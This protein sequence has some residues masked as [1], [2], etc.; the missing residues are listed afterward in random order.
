MEDCHLKN[1]ASDYEE[2]EAQ[3]AQFT[4]KA[5][6]I[7]IVVFLCLVMVFFKVVGVNLIYSFIYASGITLAGL[8][9]SDCRTNENR[10]KRPRTQ[11]GRLQHGTEGWT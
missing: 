3:S 7:S 9:L 8:I 10:A 2:G 5:L 11:A 6:T 1:L 4:N